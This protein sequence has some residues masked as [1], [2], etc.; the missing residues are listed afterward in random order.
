MKNLLYLLLVLSNS[1]FAQFK[2]KETYT[3]Y[4]NYPDHSIRANVS[5]TGKKVEAK[6]TLTY[7]WYASNKV[8]QTKGGYEGK[9]LDGPYTSF[10]LSNNLKEKGTFKMGLKDGEWISWYE[11]GKINEITNWKKGVKNGVSKT[12]DKDDQ[13]T[14]ESCYRNNELHGTLVNYENGK[15]IS[16]IKYKKGKEILPKQKKEK[17]EKVIIIPEKELKDLKPKKTFK[18]KLNSIFKKKEETEKKQP[19]P[20]EQK[21]K[22]TIKEKFASVFKKKKTTEPVITNEPKVAKKA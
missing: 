6:Q 8:L 2:A 5:N 12:F 21:P 22:R 20:S 10:Y 15:V 7:N 16:E 13:L 3:V 18:E 14:C 4:I 9:I 17:K 11:N 19:V 1:M